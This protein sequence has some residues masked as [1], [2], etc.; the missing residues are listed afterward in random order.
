MFNSPWA[1]L[2][3]ISTSHQIY[4]RTHQTPIKNASFAQTLLTLR[5][6][7]LPENTPNAYQK[8]CCGF[9]CKTCIEE[10]V[11]AL[12]FSDNVMSMNEAN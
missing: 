10:L 12:H 6:D 5:D 7:D 11:K 2:L 3:L 8:C 4:Q 1:L 9:R